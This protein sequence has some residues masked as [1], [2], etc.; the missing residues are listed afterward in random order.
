[1]LPPNVTEIRRGSAHCVAV[2]SP[3]S[4]ADR[5]IG[6]GARFVPPPAAIEPARGTHA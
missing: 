1:M 4:A 3:A 2:A 6:S 5:H